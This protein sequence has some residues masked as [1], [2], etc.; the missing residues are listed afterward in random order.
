MMGT[1][2]FKDAKPI[3][4]V[5]I[6][7]FEMSKTA[8]T[9]EQY[10]ECVIKSE[11]TK[12]GTACNPDTECGPLSDNDYCNWGKPD[13]RFHPVNCVTWDQANQYARFKGA[14]LPSESEWEYA[15]KSG[16][17]NQKYSWGN[18][19]PTCDKA[20]MY[21]NGNSGCS[22]YRDGTMPVCSKPAGNTEQGL[23]DMVGNMGQW[24]QD[25]YQNSYKGAPADGSA[26]EGEGP[27]RIA[28]GGFFSR[29]LRVDSR[30]LHGPGDSG[31]GLGFRL[32]RS[33]R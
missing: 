22:K 18:N 32:A 33:H 1:D 13:R 30:F 23:C 20:V 14:R 9:V 28:R 12:P 15:A 11:C 16:G 21:G 4:E 10:T 7:T 24:V 27:F 17:K 2:D 31:D 6:K 8:V 29:Y 5:A 19:E 26:F 25:K 3:H